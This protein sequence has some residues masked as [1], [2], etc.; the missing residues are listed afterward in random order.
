MRNSRRNA[1]E[2]MTD[3]GHTKAL[4]MLAVLILISCT[5]AIADSAADVAGTWSVQVSGDAGSASQTIIL[6]QDGNKI[7]GSFKGPR[8]SGTVDGTVDGNAIKFHVKARASLDY[9]GTVDGDSMKGTLSG[10]GKTG[11]W[12]ATRVK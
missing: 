3:A 7:T 10:R 5:V 6:K 1:E 12:T 8:Q 2:L 4:R 11:D 9:V